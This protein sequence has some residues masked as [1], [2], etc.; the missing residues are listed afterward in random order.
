MWILDVFWVKTQK[1]LGNTLRTASLHCYH[2]SSHMQTT[3]IRM[4]LAFCVGDCQQGINLGSAIM[5]YVRQNLRIFGD[6]A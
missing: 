2:L 4:G 6:L 5:K 1:L 3:N